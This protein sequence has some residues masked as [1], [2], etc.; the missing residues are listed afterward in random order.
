[1]FSSDKVRGS[2]AWHRIVELLSSGNDHRRDGVTTSRAAEPNPSSTYRTG[3]KLQVRILER[4]TN[5][6]ILV[7]WSEP[8]RCFYGHQSW[9]ATKARISGCCAFSC[10]VI[11]EGDEVYKPVYT[12]V[13]P[14]N[15][16]AMILASA[17]Y[18][19]VGR[20]AE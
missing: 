18:G 19:T 5:S 4:P 17:V 20:H 15:S 12:G 10:S 7:L 9:R 14:Q 3:T 6:T 16:Q 13:E 1:M 2:R 11:Q 8:G